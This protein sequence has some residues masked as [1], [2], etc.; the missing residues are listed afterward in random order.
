VE[1][2]HQSQLLVGDRRSESRS[3][4]QFLQRIDGHADRPSALFQD[5]GHRGGVDAPRGSRD[6]RELLLAADRPEAGGEG[7]PAIVDVSRADD[8]D[9]AGLEPAPGA[10]TEQD[11]RGGVTEAVDQGSW[12]RLVGERQQPDSE[13]GKPL[14]LEP[15][16]PPA[17]H[18][19][20]Q[21]LRWIGLDPQS[22]HDRL[23]L[24]P[25]QLAGLH[26]GRRQ[27]GGEAAPI[28]RRQRLQ[29]GAAR[30][31]HRR[32]GERD[33]LSVGGDRDRRHG[34]PPTLLSASATG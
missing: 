31:R 30:Q 11:G 15:E 10:S 13:V 26:L 4:H 18:Q 1:R 27:R 22:L 2:G 21:P 29:R 32:A 5:A 8:G 28:G 17:R 9:R 7:E 16:L 34:P 23:R 33:R 6:D 3:H 12:I 25:D 20:P 24:E 19:G 14:Q